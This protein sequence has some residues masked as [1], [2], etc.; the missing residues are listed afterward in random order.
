MAHI[1]PD[2]LR[3]GL[4]AVFC[5]TAV[6]TASRDRGGYYAGPGNEFWNYLYE[7][8]LTRVRLNPESD[9][10][11]LEFGIGLTDLVKD[12]A[13][14]SDQGLVGYD[15]A[16]F[17][18]KIRKFKPDWVVFHGKTAAKEAARGLRVQYPQLLG[19]QEWLVA[20]RPVFV[21]PSASG[22]NRDP[23]RLEG[24]A[25]RIDWFRELAELLDDKRQISD[26]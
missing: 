5:G 24:R 13:A 6:A 18:K 1:L 12:Q 22:A 8:G 15:V 10:R 26:G 7:S 23:S 4:R 3:P 25:D 20:D 17:E 9:H 14:S 19:K 2:Y 16:G 21:V 11:V